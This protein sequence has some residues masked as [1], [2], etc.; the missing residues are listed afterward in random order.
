MSSVP[1]SPLENEVRGNLQLESNVSNS[2]AV[3]SMLPKIP[4]R[5]VRKVSLK[6]SSSEILCQLLGYPHTKYGVPK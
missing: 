5:E 2:V 1:T 4:L 6:D 3:N